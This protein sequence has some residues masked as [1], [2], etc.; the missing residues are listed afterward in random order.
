M[1]SVVLCCCFEFDIVVCNGVCVNVEF[2][3]FV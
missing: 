1:L 2:I 3:Y